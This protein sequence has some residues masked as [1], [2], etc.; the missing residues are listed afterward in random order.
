[1]DDLF[2]APRRRNESLL[3]FVQ[4]FMKFYVEI[5][6]CDDA[7]AISTFQKELNVDRELYLS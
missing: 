4:R 6:D 2:T 7:L 1:M 3:N 5:L